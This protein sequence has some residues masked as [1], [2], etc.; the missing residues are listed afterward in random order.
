METPYD[1]ITVALF[2]GLIVIFLQRSVGDAPSDSALNYVPPAIGC[3]VVNYLG[4]EGYDAIAVIGIVAII[5]YIYVVI[6]PLNR[7]K[8]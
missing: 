7:S 6:D 5:V 1:W 8:R 4:N 2:S 3:A